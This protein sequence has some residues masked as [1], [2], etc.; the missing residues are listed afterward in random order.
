[1]PTLAQMNAGRK[2]GCV[3]HVDQAAGTFEVRR[4]SDELDTRSL[5]DLATACDADWAVGVIT[6][7]RVQGCC[8]DHLTED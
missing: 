1:M 5:I 6:F 8:F 3:F 7:Q 2:S 4:V